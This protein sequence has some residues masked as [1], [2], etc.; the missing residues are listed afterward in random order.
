MGK[1][2]G[3]RGN[4]PLFIDEWFAEKGAS[5]EKVA[6][7]LGVERV[8]VWRWRTQQHRLNPQKLAELA[9]A[10]GIR[11]AQFYTRPGQRSLDALLGD[12]DDA[13]RDL[14]VDIVSRLLRDRT[15]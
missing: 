10:I 8:T 3:S 7:I 12:A 5:D 11:P 6:G 2:E 9:R 14:A 4:R 13:T 15:R 1:E